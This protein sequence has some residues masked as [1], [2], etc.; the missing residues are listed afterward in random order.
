M[1]WRDRYR[2]YGTFGNKSAAYL[3]LREL[4]RSGRK[5][6][7]A[8]TRHLPDPPHTADQWVVL[9]EKEQA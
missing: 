1:S 3:A 4:R 6:D 9:V 2:V 7:M 8:E 5:S